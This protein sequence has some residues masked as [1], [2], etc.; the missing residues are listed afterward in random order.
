MVKFYNCASKASLN[1]NVIV[2]IR[3]VCAL[4]GYPELFMSGLRSKHTSM[5]YVNRIKMHMWHGV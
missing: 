2:G 3:I 4:R 1:E 5:R